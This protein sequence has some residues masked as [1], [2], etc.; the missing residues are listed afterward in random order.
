MRWCPAGAAH[1]E[2][3]V[4]VWPHA[5]AKIG[6]VPWYRNNIAPGCTSLRSLAGARSAREAVVCVRSQADI[7]MQRLLA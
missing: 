7:S 2:L 5:K 4:W 6:D 3:P 1:V